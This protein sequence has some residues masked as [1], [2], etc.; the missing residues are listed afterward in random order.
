[1]N[2]AVIL[3][4]GTGNRMGKKVPKQFLTVYDKPI[5]IYTL[6]GFQNNERIDKIICVCL[7]GWEKVLKAYCEQ[8]NI[9]KLIDIIPGGEVGQESIYNGLLS[10]K[11]YASNED[12][13]V[14]HDGVR[15]MVND[16]VLNN[17]LETAYE[18][19]NAVTSTR[20]TD[21]IQVAT[22]ENNSKGYYKRDGL[23]KVTTP[24]AYKFKFIMEAYERA[25]K[26]SNGFSSSSYANTM[27]LDQGETLYFAEGSDKNLKL[28][29]VED[30]D[31][32]KSLLKTERTEWIKE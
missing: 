24:Q 23:R 21:Q 25:L 4:S 28:T 8:F 27:L 29:T 6:E 15:P 5:I 17:V 19:G 22:T 11:K 1:M 10:A 7:S 13:V 12:L 14:I 31:I 16:K 26:N 32:F 9:D 20:V 3:E 18:K 30:L 2:I